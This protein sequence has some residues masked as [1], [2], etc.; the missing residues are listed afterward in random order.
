MEI[1]GKTFSVNPKRKKSVV[2]R[3]DQNESNGKKEGIAKP[4]LLCG[5]FEKTHKGHP[6]TDNRIRYDED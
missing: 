5:T 4:A 3:R 6:R 1:G 2:Q